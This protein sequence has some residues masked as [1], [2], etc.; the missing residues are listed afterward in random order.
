MFQLL[1]WLSSRSKFQLLFVDMYRYPS[2]VDQERYP[3]GTELPATSDLKPLTFRGSREGVLYKQR[4]ASRASCR[5]DTP[6]VPHSEVPEAI[7]RALSPKSDAEHRRLI[8][9]RE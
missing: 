7:E 4:Q 3:L 1:A 2:C 9:E 5:Y 6:C 8:C